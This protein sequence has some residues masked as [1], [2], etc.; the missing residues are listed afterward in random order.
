M[1]NGS[2][3]KKLLIILRTENRANPN[4]SSC[5]HFEYILVKIFREKVFFV[6]NKFENN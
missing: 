1:Q 2:S 4:P 5:I 6:R 3:E